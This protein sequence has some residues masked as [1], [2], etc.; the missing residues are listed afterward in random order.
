MI[1]RLLLKKN[2]GKKMPYTTNADLPD[3]VR[4]HLPEHAQ[5]IYR[6]AYNSAYHLY[7]DPAKRRNPQDSLE[8]VCAAIAWSAVKK[9][10]EKDEKS[11]KWHAK[12]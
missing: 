1:S 3:S 9:E 4:E 6:K 5:E 10:Y 2:W 8:A 11:G 7:Q 12:K